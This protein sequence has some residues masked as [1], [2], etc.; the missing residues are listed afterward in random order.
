MFD[1]SIEEINKIVKST[2]KDITPIKK[3]NGEPDFE[4]M[5]ILFE[6][7]GE[8]FHIIKLNDILKDESKD[9]IIVYVTLL[10]CN[11]QKSEIN[12]YGK[13]RYLGEIAEV[14]YRTIHRYPKK[15]LSQKEM[16]S[17]Y[18][19]LHKYAINEAI[20]TA[21]VSE[22]YGIAGDCFRLTGDF[23]FA[24]ETYQKAIDLCYKKN[25]TSLLHL[26]GQNMC[27]CGTEYFT[28][29]GENIKQEA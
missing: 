25:N 4:R 19:T 10:V 11:I 28:N 13:T 27:L 15:K 14:L 20:K 23:E 3:E 21:S 1:K 29:W 2:L 9:N 7:D 26:L 5:R 12:D 16:E 24:V 22:L 8:W 18:Y 6:K 17:S